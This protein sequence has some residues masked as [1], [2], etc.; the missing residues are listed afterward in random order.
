[1][2]NG[3]KMNMFESKFEAGKAG[4]IILNANIV[5]ARIMF[6]LDNRNYIYISIH[7]N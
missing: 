3:E 4:I 7:L 2:F 6:T 1:M 5:Y